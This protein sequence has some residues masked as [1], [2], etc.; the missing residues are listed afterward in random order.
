MS[1]IH[2]CVAVNCSDSN[3]NFMIHSRIVC[4][5]LTVGIVWK[6]CR[7][8]T[9]FNRTLGFVVVLVL[10][11]YVMDL[12]V[13][14]VD[15]LWNYISKYY[16]FVR[17]Q[18]VTAISSYFNQF[19][20]VSGICSSISYNIYCPIGFLDLCFYK[21][22]LCIFMIRIAF[23]VVA[24]Q[25]LTCIHSS[26]NAITPSAVRFDPIPDRTINGF[27]RIN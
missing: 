1:L 3:H 16:A 22:F 2:V 24:D 5:C 14:D 17:I 10:R 9:A 18:N 27:S 11:N 12:I 8:N 20:S 4:E 26:W 21:L 13:T 15:S 23:D 6:C 7:G 19:L 25:I